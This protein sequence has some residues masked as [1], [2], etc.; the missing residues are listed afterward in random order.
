MFHGTGHTALAYLEDMTML[1]PFD[2]CVFLAQTNQEKGSSSGVRQP[3]LLC[4][5]GIDVTEQGEI[6]HSDGD[7]WLKWHLDTPETPLST[8]RAPLE[9][10]RV[11]W[12]S[13]MKVGQKGLVQCFP[14]SSQRSRTSTRSKT[15][16][17]EV[18]DDDE[19]GKVAIMPP[20]HRYTRK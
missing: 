8:F 1:Q 5:N 2:F 3:L 20:D 10:Y 17:L 9:A 19:A 13:I 16:C 11:Q 7:R 4:L 12:S 14:A 18:D 15:P 6:R